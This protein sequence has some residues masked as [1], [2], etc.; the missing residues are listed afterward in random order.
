MKYH[1]HLYK[2]MGF[3]EIVIDANSPED[4]EKKAIVLG[5]EEIDTGLR[6]PD[7]QY[8]AEVYERKPIKHNKLQI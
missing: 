2:V 6:F 8:V 1:V 3:K 7:K 5:K 4:A